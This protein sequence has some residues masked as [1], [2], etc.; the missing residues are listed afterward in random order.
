MIGDNRVE[1]VVIVHGIAD[2][3][4]TYTLG[5][6]GLSVI[7]KVGDVTVWAPDREPTG[8]RR[9]IPWP[10]PT[11]CDAIRLHEPMNRERRSARPRNDTPCRLWRLPPARCKASASD[12]EFDA[13]R[14]AK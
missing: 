14:G 8:R 9:E 6:V 10:S 2:P 7:L 13:T 11:R 1:R 5:A 12:C 4:L 3:I